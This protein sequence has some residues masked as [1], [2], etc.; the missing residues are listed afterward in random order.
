MH[1]AVEAMI[2]KLRHVIEP[3]SSLSD[4]K[5]DLMNFGC[6]LL[7]K[8]GEEKLCPSRSF[9]ARSKHRKQGREKAFF[10]PFGLLAERR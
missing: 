2:A 6:S 1:R 8:Y 5:S 3:P 4:L 9:G 10:D 7:E